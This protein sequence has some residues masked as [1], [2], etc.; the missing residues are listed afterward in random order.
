MAQ[1]RNGVVVESLADGKR[2]AA[3]A[4]SRIT[5]LA[6]ISIYTN[7]GEVKLQEVLLKIREAVGEGQAPTSKSDTSVIKS[8]FAEALPDY[9]ETR[10]HV[11]H[12]KKILD[13]YGE[14]DKFASFDF[15]DPDAEAEPEEE[16]P[17]E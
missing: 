4:R 3:D 15:S 16:K 7:D 13:W 2:S 5:T 11:S 14:L 17:E 1:A 9:D 12:M 8:L 10:F 6:D